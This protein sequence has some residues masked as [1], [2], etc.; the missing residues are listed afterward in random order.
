MLMTRSSWD[1]NAT[2]LT[3]HVRG[4][5]GGHPY[6]DRNGIMLA[7]QGRTWVTIPNK[8]IGGWAMNTV[9]FDDAEQN[10]T[11]PGRVVDFVDQPNATFMTGDSKAC[12]DR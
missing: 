3:M 12:W 11:T 2:M 7:G 1:K 6:P 10:S 5:S 4:A 9:L 8:D